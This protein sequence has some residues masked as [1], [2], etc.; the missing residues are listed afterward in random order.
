[1][2]RLPLVAADGWLQAECSQRLCSKALRLAATLT[3]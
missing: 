2:L 1:M 3:G